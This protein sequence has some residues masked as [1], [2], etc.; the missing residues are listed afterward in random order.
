MWAGFSMAYCVETPGGVILVDAGSPG[1]APLFL[2]HLRRIG[3]GAPRAIFVTHAHYDHFGS[4]GALRRATG[5][6]VLIHAD[7]APDLAAGVTRLGQ[8]RG[9]GRV[10]ARALPLIERIAPPEPTPP[11]AVVDDGHTLTGLGVA[12]QVVHTPGHTRGSATLVVDGVHA[13]VGDLISATGGRPHA[14]R[15]IAQDWTA[16]PASLERL[17][18]LRV[19]WLYPGH[20]RQPVPGTLLPRLI[21][22]ARERTPSI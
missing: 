5:A 13:F 14:Q 7:D 1:Q 21:Q 19:K 9:W 4:A 17:Q 8:V 3:R 22:E 12:V 2:R 20:G 6:P 18:A 10:L 16:I 11:D 15:F